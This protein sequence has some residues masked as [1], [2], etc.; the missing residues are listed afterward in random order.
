MT[1]EDVLRKKKGQVLIQLIFNDGVSLANCQILDVVNGSIVL[2]TEDGEQ[3]VESVDEV[4]A[5]RG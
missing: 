2:L 3:I 4:D 5:F 1:F